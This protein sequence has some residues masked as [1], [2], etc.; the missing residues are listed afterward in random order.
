MVVIDDDAM[1]DDMML[2]AIYAIAF[3]HHRQLR[4][5]IQS[6]AESRPSAPADAD[7]TGNWPR[8]SLRAT[9]Y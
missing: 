8:R 5:T 7:T 4:K 1:H 2:M 6:S 3:N 9:S